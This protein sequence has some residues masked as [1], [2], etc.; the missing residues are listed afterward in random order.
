MDYRK[1]FCQMLDEM[2][3]SAAQL[4]KQAKVKEC[5]ISLFRNGKARLRVD[6]FFALIEAADVISP[7]ARKYFAL[8]YSEGFNTS[9]LVDSLSNEQL[10]DILM[11]AASRIKSM[12]PG[13][14]RDEAQMQNE[15]SHV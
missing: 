10:G 8:Q 11:S 4:A 2:G 15:L 7:G 12:S 1:I 9:N 5:Q 13:Q 6:T 3:I 14:K